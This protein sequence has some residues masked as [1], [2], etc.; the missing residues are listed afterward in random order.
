ME[1]HFKIQVKYRIMKKI[2]SV[3]CAVFLAASHVLLANPVEE[4]EAR[5]IASEFAGRNMPGHVLKSDQGDGLYTAYVSKGQNGEPRFYV[6]NLGHDGGF[7]IVSGDSRTPAV[8]GYA[9]KGSFRYEEVPENMK[10]WLSEYGRQI[11]RIPEGFVMKAKVGHDLLKT[12][13]QESISPLLGDIAY[14][15]DEP[16][17]NLC[18]VLP[19]GSTAPTGCVATAVA[20]IMRYYGH[21]LAG[22]GSH[23]YTWE[24][25]NGGTQVLSA[26]FGATQYDWDN[27]LPSYEEGYNDDQA[28]AVATLMYH[29]GVAFEMDYAPVSLVP[30]SSV[31]PALH[32]FFGYDG[33][34]SYRS[35]SDYNDED[36]KALIRAELEAGRPVFYGGQAD[37]GGHAFVL[38][39][40]QAD[41]YFHV[42]WGW[43]G[44]YDGYFLLDA[45]NPEGQGTG[46]FEGGYNRYQEMLIGIQPEAGGVFQPVIYS[47]GISAVDDSILRDGG[48]IRLSGNFSN[49]DWDTA[50]AEIGMLVYDESEELVDTLGLSG[51]VLFTP[52]GGGFV[53]DREHPFED[54][55]PQDLPE[56]LYKVYYGYRTGEDQPWKRVQISP[57]TSSCVQAE[58]KGEKVYFTTLAGE[59][60][61]EPPAT[62]ANLEV[63]TEGTTTPGEVYQ[64]EDFTVE[65]LIVNS[66]GTDF[67]GELCLVMSTGL[68]ST[69]DIVS[70][71]WPATPCHVPGNGEQTVTF[72]HNVG[73][74][75]PGTY[76]FY[77]AIVEG[78]M[79]EALGGESL[80]EDVT[81]CRQVEVLGNGGYEDPELWL[82][83]DQTE[84]PGQVAPNEDF[85]IST[86]V[87][88]TGGD[89]TGTLYMTL[90]QGENLAY[91]S[92]PVVATVPS[93]G[94]F[95]LSFEGS[96]AG[97]SEGTYDLYIGYIDGMYLVPIPMDNGGYLSLRV[98]EGGDAGEPELYRYDAET[99]FPSVIYQNEDFTASTVLRNSGSDFSGNITV[100]LLDE[101][102]SVH[103][104]TTPI[105]AVVPANGS[106]PVNITGN[107]GMLAT[108]NYLI[109]FGWVEGMS[110]TLIAD[111]EG[112][113]V[114]SVQVKKQRLANE[115]IAERPVFRVYPNPVGDYLQADCQE[116]ME[117]IRVYSSFGSILL[118]EDCQGRTSCRMETASLPAGLYLLQVET[119]SGTFTERFVK[120]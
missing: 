14:N 41:D 119:G 116:G 90:F 25:A 29:L 89:Y 58:V 28:E 113:N 87:M 45:L 98:G 68:F 37:G 9:E 43:S 23:S 104:N 5:R 50:H 61:P 79:M 106:A 39:G 64:H 34:M 101:S 19:D 49:W 40:C 95:P 11:E 94:S 99:D 114:S 12:G 3:F 102:G 30:S 16:F 107:V 57:D 91:Q 10:W 22:T 83:S 33:A 82:V 46:G 100:L 63:S 26:D 47:L 35:R 112:Y 59:G 103:Y 111:E 1:I 36:W 51:Q 7:V 27:M 32:G 8:L 71:S 105:Q 69:N 2:L 44:R 31:P 54:A 42:N 72:T 88:N 13:K 56:G 109:G 38:D 81:W 77:V 18:P 48:R 84:Y 60:R 70:Y 65:A 15:Q 118:E 117:R 73:G 4:A 53:F 20:Q 92:Q 62:P 75:S 76:Y 78:N 115:N 52:Y 120:R 86:V 110:V 97:L 21:P 17:N 96:T 6:F 66:G 67:D 93:G 55:W 74:L 24:N 85:S 80:P 108:G